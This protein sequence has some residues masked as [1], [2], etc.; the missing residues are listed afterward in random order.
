LSATVEYTQLYTYTRVTSAFDFVTNSAGAV[1]GAAAAHRARM[2][3]RNRLQLRGSPVDFLILALFVSWQLFP[4]FP[5][6]GRTA[7]Y[8]NLADLPQF[9]WLTFGTAFAGWICGGLAARALLPGRRVFAL[10]LVLL[11]KPLILGRGLTLAEI[12]AAGLALTLVSTT[13]LPSRIAAALVAALILLRE[14]MPLRFS[15]TASA[16]NWIPFKASLGAADWLRS[17]GVL[18]DKLF[19]ITAAL[20]LLRRSGIRLWFATAAMAAGLF[21]LELL[22]TY[23]PGRTP[24]STDAAIA[25]AAGLLLDLVDGRHSSG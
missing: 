6:S 15:T 16:F 17:C 13:A 21:G 22:Q 23:L 25:L 1:I 20:W 14:V 11:V 4:F 18:V 3:W 5:V 7:L 9:G 12:A 19:L 2:E 10:A 8:A 24:E